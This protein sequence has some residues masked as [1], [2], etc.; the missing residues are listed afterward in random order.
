[1]EFPFWWDSGQLFDKYKE[2]R[3]DTGNPLYADFGLVLSSA[4]AIEWENYCREQF[5]PDPHAREPYIAESMERWQSLMGS[6][7]WVI[8]ESYEWE[9]GLS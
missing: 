6:A 8:V 2:R 1:M 5:A 7:S 3:I 9:S 4:E